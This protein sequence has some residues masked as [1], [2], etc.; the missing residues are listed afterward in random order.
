MGICVPRNAGSTLTTPPR[1]CPICGEGENEILHSQRLVTP[2]DYPLP[3]GFDVVVCSNCGMVY[4]CSSA[5]QADYDEFYSTCSVH[6]TPAEASHDEIPIWEVARL[7]GLARIVSNCAPSRG[8]RILDVGCSGGGLLKNLALSGY[9]N[10]VGIDPSPVCV[11]NARSNG[12][13]A[14]VGAAGDLPDDIGVFDLILLTG[15]L[16]HIQDLRGAVG[17]LVRASSPHGRIFLE[18]PDAAHYADFQHSPFQDFNTEHINHFSCDSL[19]NLMAPFGF[20]LVREEHITV[21][22]PSCLAF[23]CLGAVFERTSD[24]PLDIP[25]KKDETFRNSIERYIRGSSQMMIWLDQQ[26]QEALPSSPQVIVWG[27]GQLAMKLLSDTMLKHAT[28][29]AFVDGNPIYA[30]RRILGTP[31]LCPEDIPTQSAPIVITSLL[32]SAGILKTIKSLQLKNPVITL[33]PD[34]R[35]AGLE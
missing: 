26:L 3:S 30:G 29:V 12:I 5:T 4:N 19:R 6:A 21:N 18:V 34:R 15:V 27:T 1:P 9:T 28:V 35:G 13:E 14:Y 23:P 25:W 7:R 20:I 24:R 2:D 33:V 17:S 32:H 22:G 16:E 31:I 8:C 10:L 11:A